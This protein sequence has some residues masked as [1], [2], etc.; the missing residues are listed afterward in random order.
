MYHFPPGDGTGQTIALFEFGGGYFPS[1]LTQF[2]HMAGIAL[3]NI[4]PISVD[5]VATNLQD[6]QE[7][8]VMLDIE[9]VASACPKAG[10]RW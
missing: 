7:G 2:C 6:G 10:Q 4:Q 5:S 8:E 1:D 3:P 9:I